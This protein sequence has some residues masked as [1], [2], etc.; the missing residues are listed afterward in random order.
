[1]P[2]SRYGHYGEQQEQSRKGHPGIDKT[3]HR[4][5]HFP[6]QESGSA[7][8][9]DSGRATFSR[10]ADRTDCTKESPQLPDVDQAAQEVSLPKPELGTQEVLG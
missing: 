3:L 7:A 8:D 9:Q 10:V 4:Q 2:A 6:A 1:M 5:V